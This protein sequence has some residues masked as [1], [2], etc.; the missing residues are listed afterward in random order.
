MQNDGRTATFWFVDGSSYLQG[1]KMWETILN[2]NE[3]RYFEHFAQQLSELTKDPSL[4]QTWRA[5]AIQPASSS[6]PITL[7]DP[8]YVTK[9]S[10]H[11]GKLGG[12]I[13]RLE[14]L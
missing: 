10:D 14:D 11:R 6:V 5:N 13:K 4:M 7:R 12:G 1:C 2:L 3:I 9:L 8:I